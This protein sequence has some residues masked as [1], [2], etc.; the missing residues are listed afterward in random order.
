[1]LILD[2]SSF[3]IR[4]APGIKVTPDYDSYFRS[5]DGKQRNL[6]VEATGGPTWYAEYNVL[7]GLSAR[8]FGAFMF[9]VTR[10]AAGRVSRGLPTALR[11]CGYKPITL[12]PTPGAFLG[13]ERFHKTTG[14]DR[15]IDMTELGATNDRQPDSFYYGHALRTIA[16]QKGEAPLFLF[17]YTA[18]NHF[19]WSSTH[20]PQL[21]PDWKELGNGFEIDEYIRRQ[22]LS[23]RAYADFRAK[24]AKDFPSEQFLIVRFGDHQPG[25]SARILEPGLSDSA[26]GRKIL[27]FEPKYFTTYYSIDGV[28]FTPKDTSSALET[29][30]ASYLP[31]VIQEAAGLPID[32][33]FAEQKKIMQR[34]KGT[35]FACANG[36]EVRRFNRMLIDAGLIKDLGG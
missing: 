3:D 23:A 31:I 28:N 6:I 5:F 21:T 17:I 2:E 18:A 30:E 22:Y 35:F 1:V 16:R 34:C 14:V 10:L 4:V 32:P 26:I 20:Q 27:A 36:A 25:L 29:L 9:Y 11:H 8:S 33:T 12:Y 13:A 24:L 15:F 7:T 19:P